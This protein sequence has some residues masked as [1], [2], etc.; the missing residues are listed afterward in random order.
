[1]RIVRHPVDS[2]F[3]LLLQHGSMPSPIPRQEL[4]ELVEK[5]REFQEYWDTQKNVVTIRYE[6]LLDAPYETL[7]KVLKVLG[8]KVEKKDI[9][10]AVRK[11]PPR[12]GV[13][14]HASRFQQQDL[15][16]IKREL[17]DIMDE[18]GYKIK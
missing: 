9:E 13:L 6:D 14:K 1:M 16:F 17:K 18:Y 4:K 15:Q 11:N 10:R 5:F 12:G 2:V 8:Y 3:F 7:E